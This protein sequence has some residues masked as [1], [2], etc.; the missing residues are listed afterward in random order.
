MVAGARFLFAHQSYL[1][2]LPSCKPT[3][4][5]ILSLLVLRARCDDAAVLLGFVLPT[6]DLLLLESLLIVRKLGIFP[7]PNSQLK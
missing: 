4:A 6:G 7:L 3:P 5:Q 1:S 2:V